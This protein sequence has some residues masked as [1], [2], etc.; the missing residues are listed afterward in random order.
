MLA[1]KFGTASETLLFEQG[2]VNE[3]G[4]TFNSNE[5]NGSV[6]AQSQSDDCG[7]QSSSSEVSFNY[8]SDNEVIKCSKR[9]RHQQEDA[10]LRIKKLERILCSRQD[11]SEAV[12]RKLQSRKNTAVFRERQKNA[13]KFAL[14]I[15][16][17]L[18][19]FQAEVSFPKI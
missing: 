2:N 14:F 11:I 12:R 15:R 18:P 9:G 4:I 6:V 3:T 10:N 16:E 17:E 13:D 5:A 7:Y 19:L 8:D 1:K